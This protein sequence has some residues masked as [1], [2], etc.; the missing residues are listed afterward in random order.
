MSESAPP[1]M[2]ARCDRPLEPAKVTV[3]Y[4]GQRFPVDLPRCP[5]CGFVFVPEDLAIGKMLKVE[6]S[7]E[8]K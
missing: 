5:C 7:L 6:R 4:L 1:L 8:D 3:T 2:C